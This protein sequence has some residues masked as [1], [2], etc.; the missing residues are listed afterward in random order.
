MEHRE[1]WLFPT[2]YHQNA[3]ELAE[4]LRTGVAPTRLLEAAPLSEPV[5]ITHYAMVADALRV[6]DLGALRRLDRLHPLAP[7]AVERRSRR[8]EHG[9]CSPTPS[10]SGCAT[11]CGSGWG[12]KGWHEVLGL[13][14]RTRIS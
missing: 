4:P 12:P 2:A 14:P 5:R 11:R 1:F 9:R 8:P 3:A 7:E 13:V 10:S 6:E